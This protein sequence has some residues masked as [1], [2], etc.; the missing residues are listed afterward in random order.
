MINS[1]SGE[2][3][4]LSNFWPCL[5]NYN[6]QLWPSVEHA[7]QASKCKNIED[8]KLFI[9]KTAGQCKSLGKK[10]EI[11]EDWDGIKFDTML[12]LVRLKFNYP[13]SLLQEKLLMTND[14]ELIEGN[15]WGD[16]YWGVCDGQGENNLGKILMQ[17]RKEIRNSI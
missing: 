6:S 14:Q 4:F 2:Y 15:T 11:R 5:I 16:I 9:G 12:T 13:N 3:R 1:F 17:V 8:Q 7:Y 10:I